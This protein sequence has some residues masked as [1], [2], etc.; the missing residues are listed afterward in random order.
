[1]LQIPKYFDFIAADVSVADQQMFDIMKKSETSTLSTTM[2]RPTTKDLAKEAGVSRATVDRVLNGREGVKEKT[3]IRVNEAIEKLGFVRNIQAAN[4]AKSQKYR[5]VFGPCLAHRS[6]H[7][8]GKPH[9]V[10]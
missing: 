5:F 2:L 9:T 1:M 4:L 8:N 10:F 7:L 6:G 3:V